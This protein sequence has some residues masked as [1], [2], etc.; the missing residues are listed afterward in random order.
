MEKKIS[1]V[2][3]LRLW[4][5]GIIVLVAAFLLAFLLISCSD[6]QTTRVRKGLSRVT[7][8]AVYLCRLESIVFL[9]A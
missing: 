8:G 3:Y 1:P 4:I 7:E 5:V 2:D 6:S 9:K